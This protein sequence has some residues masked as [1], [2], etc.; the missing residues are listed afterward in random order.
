MLSL[1]LFNGFFV[2]HGVHGS[3]L[4]TKAM[5]VAFQFQMLE[6]QAPD[7]NPLSY[8]L[9]QLVKPLHSG[10]N[11]CRYGWRRLRAVQAK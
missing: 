4:M 11:H 6:F 5:D 9:S 7:A 8:P 3:F 1:I 10:P 2:C